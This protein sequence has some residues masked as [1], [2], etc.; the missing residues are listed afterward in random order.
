[1]KF[2]QISVGCRHQFWSELTSWI[3]GLF[4]GFSTLNGF[5]LV[6]VFSSLVSHLFLFL[7]ILGPGSHHSHYHTGF[8]SVNQTPS[9][10][11]FSVLFFNF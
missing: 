10:C 5:L 11:F 2:L 6:S 1:V 4:I 8:F 3:T 9:H 7:V